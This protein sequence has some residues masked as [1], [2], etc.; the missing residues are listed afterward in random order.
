MPTDAEI[1]QRI[2]EI[3]SNVTSVPAEEIGDA[4]RLRDDLDLD[5]LSLLEVGVD[6]DYE[7]KLGLPDEELQ[8][9][10]SVEEAVAMVRQVLSGRGD[11][12]E[13]A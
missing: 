9:I 2:K 11:Q 7:Y 10:G 4:D 5:S 6:V 12:S 3:I 8:K 1:K 13:V